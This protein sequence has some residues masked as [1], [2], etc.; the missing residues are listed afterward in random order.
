MGEGVVGI[1]TPWPIAGP[2]ANKEP[3][4]QYSQLACG[5]TWK[6]K[7][8]CQSRPSQVVV[9]KHSIVR[10]DLP[11]ACLLDSLAHKH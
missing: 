2:G 1:E 7:C 9:V 10:G 8:R 4:A 11:Y 6:M 3:H 5:Q